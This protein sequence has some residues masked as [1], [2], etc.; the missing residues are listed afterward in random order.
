[1]IEYHDLP[2]PR[3]G[4]RRDCWLAIRHI[5]G[6]IYSIHLAQTIHE[7][8]YTTKS[9]SYIVEVTVVDDKTRAGNHT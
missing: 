7:Y 1:M 4:S 8:H 6:E 9:G 3:D 2:S 5:A